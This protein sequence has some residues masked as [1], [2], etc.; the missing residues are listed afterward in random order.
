MH[1]SDVDWPERDHALYR[2]MIDHWKAKF[3]SLGFVQFRDSSLQFTHDSLKLRVEIE[4]FFNRIG[5]FSTK[6][7]G[8]L[9]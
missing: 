7:G 5:V 1:E 9:Y 3:L 2:E 4:P 8:F 6:G